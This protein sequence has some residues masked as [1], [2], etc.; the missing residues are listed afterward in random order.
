MWTGATKTVSD[1]PVGML[2]IVNCR[3]IFTARP[4]LHRWPLSIGRVIL[5]L[6]GVTF[7]PLP[8]RQAAHPYFSAYFDQPS[9]HPM[10]VSSIMGIGPMI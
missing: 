10:P 3:L 2:V 7:L 1:F 4:G 6:A 5:G 8:R 9:T